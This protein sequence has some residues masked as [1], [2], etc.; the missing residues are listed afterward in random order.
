MQIPNFG[1]QPTERSE[2]FVGY[3]QSY[4]Y[5]AARL[6]VSDP[7]FIRGTTYKRDAFDPTTD[8][9]GIVIDSYNDNENGLAF[10]TNSEAM[11]WDGTVFNDAQG[12]MPVSIDWNAF[13]DSKTTKTDSVWQ[14]EMRIPFTTLRYQEQEG[15]VTMGITIWWYMA[16]KYEVDIFPAISMEWGDNS[17]WKPSRMQKFVF[18]GLPKKKPLY[19]APYVLGGLQQTSELNEIENSYQQTD[20]PTFEAGLDVKYGLT[21]NMTLDL[22]V[23]TD[24]AQVEADDQQVNLTR[25]ELFFPEKRLFFLERASVF[26]FSFDNFNRLFYSRNIGI[27]EEDQ[28]RIYGGARI[29]GRLGKYDVGFLNM[30]T[31]ALDDLNSENFSLLRIRRKILTVNSYVGA[32]V[33]NRTDFKGNYNTTYGADAILRIFGEDYLSIKGVQSMTSDSSNQVLSL[34]PSRI[35]INWERR[36]F[37][38]FNYNFS[39]SRAG[40]DYT[41]GMGFEQRENYTSIGPEVSYGWRMDEQSKL[42]RTRLFIEGFGLQNNTSKKVETATL[43]VGLFLETKNAWN[44]IGTGIFNH[45]YVPETFELTDS[46]NVIPAG[47]YDFSQFNANI[48]TPFNQLVSV[49]IDATVGGFYDGN[50]LS[51]GLTPAIKLSSHLELSGFYQFNR[52]R[53][54]ERNQGFNAH[55]GRL[56]ALYMMNTKFSVGAFVQY[57]SQE[58]IFLGNLR[59]RYNPKEGNDLYLVYN[60][61]L[62]NNRQRE[63]PQLPFSSNRAIVLKYTHTFQL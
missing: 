58:E 38:G 15:K 42:L 18:E 14:V 40:K 19:I 63:L 1:Q 57:N 24:F 30:Q 49:F 27:H 54:K 34:D 36:R 44:I 22:T 26:D 5:L 55:V 56:K 6:F 12:D 21:S 60:D 4:L 53:F 3:D 43:K 41:P 7:A 20:D 46:T 52:V 33:T 47:E 39:F 59:I 45:E 50:L 13:W 16:A 37:D 10:F 9:F 29:V 8:Y 48:I 51:F 62:N 31:A 23:N 28:V 11:R 32:I 17:A 2:V 35:Y 25:F 61:L